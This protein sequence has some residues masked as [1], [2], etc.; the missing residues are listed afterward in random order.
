MA[1]INPVYTIFNDHLALLGASEATTKELS[2]DILL[3]AKY[4]ETAESTPLW[5]KTV[6]KMEEYKS[7]ALFKVFREPTMDDRTVTTF[8]LKELIKLIKLNASETKT[9]SVAVAVLQLEETHFELLHATS[10]YADELK[11]S[12]ESLRAQIGCLRAENENLKKAV[13]ILQETLREI[14]ESLDLFPQ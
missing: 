4:S 7:S 13:E 3:L 6:K 14:K 11:T 2:E 10:H 1:A 8:V 12:N 5:H 9:V